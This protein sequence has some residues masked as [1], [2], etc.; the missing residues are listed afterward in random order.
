MDDIPQPLQSPEVTPSGSKQARTTQPD[1]GYRYELEQLVEMALICSP[2]RSMKV[3]TLSLC[4]TPWQK[5][6][7]VVKKLTLVL[8]ILPRKNRD[9]LTFSNIQEYK[10]KNGCQTARAAELRNGGG[11]A[12]FEETH[13]GAIRM[14]PEEDGGR[15]L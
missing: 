12:P 4:K 15:Q 5:E 14:T 8:Q 13:H 7:E 10:S 11:R 9:H 2:M 1:A 6:N 3:I